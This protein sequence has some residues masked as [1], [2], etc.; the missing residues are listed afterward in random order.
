MA[1]PPGPSSPT[2]EIHERGPEGTPSLT[3]K[4]PV[5]PEDGPYGKV[6]AS[7]TRYRLGDVHGDYRVGDFLATDLGALGALTRCEGLDEVDPRDFLFMDTETTGLSGGAGTMAF[8]VGLAWFEEDH[9]VVRQLFT[10]APGREGPALREVAARMGSAPAICSYNGRAFDWTL[11]R[12]RFIL[13]RVAVPNITIHVDLLHA[14]RRIWA[15]RVGNARL[16]NI[17]AEVLGHHRVDDVPGWMIPEV[18]FEYLASGAVGPLEGVFTHNVLDLVSLAGVAHRLVEGY[19]GSPSA[20][21]PLDAL[22]YAKAA[23][24]GEAWEL[25]RAFA[26]RGTMAIGHVAAPAWRLL[27]KLAR[28]AGDEDGE[29]EALRGV[30]RTETP[31][32]ASDAHLALAKFF[33][34]RR[35][36]PITALEHAHH[37][38]LAEGRIAHERRITRLRRRLQGK[39]RSS[40]R[41]RPGKA[42]VTTS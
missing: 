42:R 37:T 15:R 36:V 28:R 1:A 31:M 14:A 9:F 32:G 41:S 7:E 40:T 26:R 29:E 39:S 5:V 20:S 22:G 16:V 3:S 13:N 8:L 17:E 27:A 12:N 21:E 19:R 10:P 2:K 38:L 24:E 18:Y 11:L 34:H 23:M 30:L 25:A 35:R 33:E 6:W 4:V